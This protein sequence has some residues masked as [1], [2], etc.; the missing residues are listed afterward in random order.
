MENNN[1]IFV[2]RTLNL[3]KIKYLGFDQDH[4]L[5]RYKSE[6]FER[7]S[8]D[9]VLEKLV[10][11]RKYPAE[12][13]NLPFE[14]NRVT[15]GLV[16]DKKHGNLL[17]L[18]SHGYIRLSSHGT[19]KIEFHEQKK[20]Y[21]GSHLDLSDSN[22]ICIDTAF[23][24]SYANLFAR[25]VDLKDSKP[26][27][28]LPTYGDMSDD[29]LSSVDE[30]HRDGSLKDEVA[31]NLDKYIIRDP[32]TAMHLERY[33]K[34]GKKLF[35]LTNS[36]YLYSKTLMDYAIQPFLKDHKSWQDVFEFV[37]TLAHKPRFFYDRLPFL[38][39]NPADGSLTNYDTKLV[40]GIYQG[41]CAE[42]FTEALGLT[43]ED[44]LYV[45]DH[46]YG[47]IVRLKKDCA[48][49]TALVVEE[50][51]KEVENIKNASSIQEQIRK[52]MLQKKPLELELTEAEDKRKESNEKIDEKRIDEAFSQIN[53]IDQQ[54]SGFIGQYEKEFNPYWG[55][56]MRCGVEESY[57]AGQVARYAC[58]YTP[59]LKDL[60][61]ASP[62]TYFRGF[63]RD[64]PHEA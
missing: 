39:V 4:T 36:D 1:K 47:D 17:K 11:K 56:L 7:L 40:K 12:V 13:L 21:R 3:K 23:S 43:G 14:Y 50:L 45:G 30:A 48:W 46:I 31:K 6:N 51:E 62:R 2:N 44:I 42:T 20:L 22:F 60:L 28:N 9:K 5:V 25:L 16:I 38:K 32:E 8:H 41:G 35:L 37:I 63:R 57:F 27:L 49:R 26:E 64:M 55:E 54:I 58:I 33:I 10:Q 53:Q 59:A 34:H 15:R 19:R 24:I 61:A 52:L 18:N 29:I